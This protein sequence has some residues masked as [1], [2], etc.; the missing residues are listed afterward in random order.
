MDTC[1]LGNSIVPKA[2]SS[3]V[4]D[5]NSAAEPIRVIPAH[6]LESGTFVVDWTEPETVTGDVESSVTFTV[7]PLDPTTI[8]VKT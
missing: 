8:R 4:V 3:V 7:V 1:L 5:S 2:D 6:M